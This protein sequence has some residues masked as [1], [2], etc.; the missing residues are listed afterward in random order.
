[1]KRVSLW[2]V[3]I[4]VLVVGLAAGA[5]GAEEFVIGFSNASRGNAWAAQ[6][7]QRVYDLLDALPNVTHMYADGEDDGVK[8]LSDVE[9]M[10]ARGMDLLI[11]RPSTPE[12]LAVVV[13]QV[14]DLGIPVVVS[15][16]NVATDKFT[17][18]V[19]V[20]DVDLGR[21]T[22]QAAVDMLVEKYGEPRGKVAIIQGL[23]AAGSARARDQ[24][25]MEILDQYPG[26]EIVARQPGEY[27]RADARTVMENI[28]M[29]Q[30]EIDV[31]ITHAGEMAV[32]AIEAMKAAGRRGEFPVTSVDGNNGF[33]KAIAAGD[34]HFTAL[35][36]LALGDLTV[37]V[38]MRILAGEEVEKIIAM[39]VP[40]VT[41]ENI[42]EF[43]RLDQP[44]TYFTY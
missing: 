8:Q 23:M 17:S 15:G 42:H 37:D 22:A 36:P 27:R 25:T 7:A 32:G 26:I 16:R 31:L 33:L 13:E 12:I 40:N 20:D 19:W 41:P 24:G 43:V 1:M 18:F 38:A 44:D 10:L 34:G 6:Y 14:Y 9:D 28:L 2:A 29:A 11:I 39:D 21:R 5:A 35:Y 30:P 4:A 3:L